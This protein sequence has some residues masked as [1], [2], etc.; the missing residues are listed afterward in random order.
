MIVG[1]PKEIKVQE[2]RVGLVPASVRELILLDTKVFVEHNAGIGIGFTD[3]DYESA[4]AVVVDTP[5]EVYSKSELIVK[6][7]E[8]QSAECKMLRE[9]QVIFTFLHLAAD[10]TQ[11]NF[12]KESGCAAIAYETVTDEHKN[13]PLLSP[14]SEIAGR[15]SVQAGAHCLEK[16]N[17]GSGVLLGGA[18]GV[19]RGKIVILGAGVV[20]TNALLVAMGLGA[21]VV[22]FDK[23]LS[24]LR[25]LEIAFGSK[26][27]TMFA[28][29][30][31]IEKYA[32]QADLII[33]AILIPGGAAPKIITREMLSHMR[34]GSVLVDVSIDQG[35]CFET[36]RPTTYDDPT[37]LEEGIVHY[38]VA[39]MPGA[40]PRTSTFALNNATLPFILKI[41]EKGY[42]K[43]MIEDEH[44]LN[45]LNV[46]KGHITHEAV[47]KDLGFEYVQAKKAL[48]EK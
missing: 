37:Y 39:N 42:K 11:A 30:G 17:G 20:G 21:D 31:A 25:E 33:G 18:A 2:H 1:I 9:N 29:S 19:A 3:L 32:L 38:C 12:L 27:T 13:L 36:S 35:G 15:L 4:G 43:A 23:S 40:V 7:K 41:V 16:E 34:T 48:Q 14:M 8:P 6:I 45:G 10:P 44:L 5:E 24:R 46:Y 47:A 26:I 22:I 28:T